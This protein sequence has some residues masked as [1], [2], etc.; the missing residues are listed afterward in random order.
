MKN[1]LMIGTCVV[2]TGCIG[3]FSGEFVGSPHGYC[4]SGTIRGERVVACP[5]II[6]D[7]GE[8]M[9]IYINSLTG[10]MATKGAA[11]L[12]AKRDLCMFAPDAI[13]CGGVV[14]Q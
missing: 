1:V 9:D 8:A 14:S 10:V 11:L 7:G 13:E 2:L 5:T 12:A 6:P 3:G 4:G